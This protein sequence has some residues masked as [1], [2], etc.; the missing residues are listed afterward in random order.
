ML[1]YIVSVAG[2]AI[3][4]ESLTHIAA[5]HA[6]CEINILYHNLSPRN[7]VIVPGWDGDRD[8]SGSLLID[9]DLCKV[10][11]MLANLVSVC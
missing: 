4:S 5:H 9:W 11:D 8:T 10:T 6:T 1:L 2:F 7:I 3:Y